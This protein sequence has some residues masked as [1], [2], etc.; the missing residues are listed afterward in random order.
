MPFVR[1]FALRS[2]TLPRVMLVVRRR[3]LRPGG[4]GATKQ[5]AHSVIPVAHCRGTHSA[6]ARPE[7]GL[8]G[9]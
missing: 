5:I 2:A 3:G 4:G 6:P 1:A 9:V 7:E 8:L